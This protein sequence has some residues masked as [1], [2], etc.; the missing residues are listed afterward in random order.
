MKKFIKTD[1]LKRPTL[2]NERHFREV[3]AIAHPT[4]HNQAQYQR[5]SANL[6][7]CKIRVNVKL[8][9]AQRIELPEEDGIIQNKVSDL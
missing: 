9:N 7:S 4:R 6:R 2:P 5:L 1:H 8:L 3:L